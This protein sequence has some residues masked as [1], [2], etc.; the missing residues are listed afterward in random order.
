MA[1]KINTFRDETART[2]VQVAREYRRKTR[3]GVRVHPNAVLPRGLGR[4]ICKADEEIAALAGSVPGSGAGT[5]W[6][7]N[8][9]DELEESETT[10]TLFNLSEAAVTAG[11]FLIAV[12]V[13]GRICVIVESCGGA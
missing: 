2:L 10:V 12:K 6:H 8:E 4:Y 11:K 1:K 13:E 3:P 9:D 5:L 7:F